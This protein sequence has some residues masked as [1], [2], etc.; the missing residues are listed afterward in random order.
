MKKLLTLVLA[1]ALA[2]GMTACS[3]A[4]SSAAPAPASSEETPASSETPAA[5]DHRFETEYWA[6]LGEDDPVTWEAPNNYKRVGMVVPDGTSEFYVTMCTTAEEIF[7]GQGYTL[8]WTGA[9]DSEAAINAIE[10]WVSQGVD[11]LILLVQDTACE[12]AALN[13]MKQGVLVVL[14]SATFS[15][16]HVWCCQ[17]YVQIGRNVAEMA[18]KDM[19]EKFGDDASYIIMGGT[20]AQFQAWKTQGVREG[21]QDFYPNGTAYEIVDAANPQDDV[22][23]LL[24]QHPEIK[25]IVSWHTN[26]TLAAMSAL[27]TLNLND[28][29]NFAVYGSQMVQQSLI[30]IKDPESCYVADTWMG[31]QGRQY[32]NVV[33]NL[34][35]GGTVNHWDKAPDIVVNAANADTYYEEYYQTYGDSYKY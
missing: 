3:S 26:Y 21:M 18:A 13:A 28:P 27:D 14:G 5:E 6:N 22:E 2:L 12:N 31:D 32:A 19:K 35:E 25:A 8:N 1:I 16:Y 11:A 23:T 33:L 20:K 4:S 10:T 15:S 29:A 34:L 30:E 9:N 24:T 7:K 17:D